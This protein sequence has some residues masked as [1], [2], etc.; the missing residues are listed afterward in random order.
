MS[1][2]FTDCVRNVREFAGDENE[3]PPQRVSYEGFPFQTMF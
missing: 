3:K 2:N 1:W